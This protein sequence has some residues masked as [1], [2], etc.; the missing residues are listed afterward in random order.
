MLAAVAREKG[1]SAYVGDGQNLWPS[2]HRL[3]AAR[4]FRLAVERGARNEA[5]HAIA[6]AGVP[7]RLIAEAISRQIGVP[8]QSLT[9]EEAETHFG[10]LAR[11]VA[12]NGPASSERTRAVLGWEP[13]ERGIIS[14]IDRPEYYG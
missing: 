6:E 14:D 8:A 2:V 10:G 7:F 13:R 11:W 4:V 5:F 1:V 12:G 3:D 9:P